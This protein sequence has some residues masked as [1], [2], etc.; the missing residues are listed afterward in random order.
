MTTNKHGIEVLQDPSLNKTT[1]FT[2]TEKQALGI[3]GLVPDTTES[4]E[5]KLNRVRLQLKEN[6]TDL[7]QFIYLMNLLDTNETVFYRTLMSDPARFLEIVYDPTIGEACLKFDHIFRRPHGMYLSISRQGHVR[8]VLRNWPVKD[9]RFICVTN[10]GRILALGDLGA[11]GMAIPMGKL[12]LYPAAAGVPPEGLL[13]MYLDAG[14][15]NETY[16]RDPLYVGLRQQRPSSEELYAFVDEFVEAVQE[17]FPNCCI[18]FE[19]WTGVDAVALLARYRNKASCYNDD[20]Q[21]T[22]GVTLAGLINALKITGG[23]LKD[24]RILFLGSGSAAI[25]LADLIVSALVQQ[26]V[27]Q[28]AARQQIRL[29]DTKGLV[30]AGRPGLSES[31]RH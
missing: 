30:V 5:T 31:K 15:N 12:Q 27:S 3:V 8:E 2:E 11:N 26:G 4:I 13:P 17:I 18:H 19:D 28:E 14:T 29:F 6:A 25:G 23:Q 24:Q 9:V 1:G 10:A 7:D 21:G 16:L 22:A 20:I